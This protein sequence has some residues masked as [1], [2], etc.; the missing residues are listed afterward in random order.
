MRPLDI[1]TIRHSFLNTALW[2]EELDA[3]FEVKDFM[4]SAVQKADQIIMLF[5]QKAPKE[6]LECYVEHFSAEPEEQLGHDLWLS[7]NGHGAGFFDHSLGGEENRLQN[8][9]REM[10]DDK[11][12][13]INQ[14][15]VSEMGNVF[16]E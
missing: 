8:T 7:L 1:P 13:Y 10:R 2:T 5:I 15:W 9:C 3:D 4:P 12:A 16:I 14:V 6:A 11:T